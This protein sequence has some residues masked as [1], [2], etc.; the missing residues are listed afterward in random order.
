MC[1]TRTGHPMHN[2]L[3]LIPLAPLAGAALNGLL[4]IGFAR[5]EKGPS[6]KLVSLIGCAAPLASFAIVL[7]LF[8]A[9]LRMAPESRLFE[10]TLF[11]WLVSGDI[12]VDVAYWVD[13]LSMTMLL[14]VTGIG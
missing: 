6:E 3:W 13:P 1:G 2:L 4:A 8:V 10:Q 14:I 7:Q 9:M 12:R 5:R 11:T